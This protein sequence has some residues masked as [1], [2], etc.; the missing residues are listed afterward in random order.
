M[1]NSIAMNRILLTLL[2]LGFLVSLRGQETIEVTASCNLHSGINARSITTNAPSQK[3]LAYYNEIV[4]IAGRPP[5]PI[6][7][8]QSQQVS[9][10]AAIISRGKRYITYNVDFLT[11]FEGRSL[12]SWSAKFLLAHEIGHHYLEHSLGGNTQA[13]N[14]RNEFEADRFAAGILAKM[15]A[16]LNETIGGI[17][18]LVEF[19]NTNS[20]SHPMPDVR[21]D[22]IRAAWKGKMEQII[23]QGA[24]TST[25]YSKKALRLDKKAFRNQWNILSEAKA[26]ADGEKIT[27]YY[28]VPD[29]MSAENIKVCVLSADPDVNPG[30]NDVSLFNSLTD[31]KRVTLGGSEQLIWNY[32]MDKYAPSQVTKEFQFRLYAFDKS[33]LPKPPAPFRTLTGGLLLG[34]GTAT[35]VVGVLDWSSGRNIYNNTYV[36]TREPAD[37]Q[38]ADDKYFRG[39]ILMAAGAASALWGIRVFNRANRQQK[40]YESSSCM[41]PSEK[42]MDKTYLTV[43][44]YGLTV[45]LAFN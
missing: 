36:L 27:F 28:N 4:R 17:S 35:A 19:Q 9:N 37:Y 22:S 11:D 10:A 30:R 5:E 42:L 40:Q 20:F 15:D 1:N 8:G 16:D 26:E 18:T 24:N 6:K 33:K 2:F 34:V 21:I 3:M 41:L 13:E 45:G 7:L 14:H 29:R 25:V 43:N 31:R 23:S 12:T 44:E 39:Q 32:R 38:E